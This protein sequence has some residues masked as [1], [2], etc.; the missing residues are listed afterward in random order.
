MRNLFFIILEGICTNK[1][2]RTHL[3]AQYV[4]L[5]K[6]SYLPSASILHIMAVFLK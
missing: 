4:S 2:A 1:N 3:Q 6:V 5:G